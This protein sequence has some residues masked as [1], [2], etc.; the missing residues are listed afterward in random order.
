MC[1]AGNIAAICCSAR[2]HL[3]QAI[4]K[5]RDGASPTTAI[6]TRRLSHARKNC[7]NSL[8]LAGEHALQA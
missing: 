2:Q 8:S 7:M 1:S 3:I 6:P 5:A 4:N